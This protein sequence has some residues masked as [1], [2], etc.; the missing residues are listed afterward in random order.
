MQ[1]FISIGPLNRSPNRPVNTATQAQNIKIKSLSCTS[2]L[3]D[4][5][6]SKSGERSVEIV[7]GGNKEE[8]DKCDQRKWCP[9]LDF[10]P[11]PENV[12]RPFRCTTAHSGKHSCVRLHTHNVRLREH[13]EWEYPPW[14]EIFV[15]PGNLLMR[16]ALVRGFGGVECKQA[17]RKDPHHRH[18]HH[19][20]C[21]QAASIKILSE[22][23]NQAICME[24][25]TKA[26]VWK[27]KRRSVNRLYYV[28]EWT[29]Q[30]T[31]VDSKPG[32]PVQGLQML[33]FLLR[34]PRLAPPSGILALFFRL[35]PYKP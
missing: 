8:K 24:P 14:G 23:A 10:L 2:N 26:F 15:Q 21:A 18:H 25:K 12:S 34:S 35:L 17:E 20:F 6:K 28:W 11:S 22:V 16:L 32:H 33:T 3:P 7:E 5:D 30:R 29:P 31:E 1:A 27:K 4:Y 9:T 13:K 19:P